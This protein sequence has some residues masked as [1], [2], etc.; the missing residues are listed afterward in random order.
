MSSSERTRINLQ[1][2]CV[3]KIRNR[4]YRMKRAPRTSRFNR[5]VFISNIFISKYFDLSTDM[6]IR[7]LTARQLCLSSKVHPNNYKYWVCLHFFCFRASTEIK[8]E[9]S[10]NKSNYN[11]FWSARCASLENPCVIF[12]VSHNNFL[13]DA[14]QSV[15]VTRVK[16]LYIYI[17]RTCNC[18]RF[19]IYILI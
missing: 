19:S 18:C 13:D 14:V 15:K 4:R 2:V 17:N 11:A 10:L 1:V 12:A 5:F 6:E 8:A 7:L 9:R 16:Y 3:S